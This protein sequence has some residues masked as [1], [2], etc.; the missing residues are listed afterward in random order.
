MKV[1]EGSVKE[2]ARR[3]CAEEILKS[4]PVKLGRHEAKSDVLESIEEARY[5]MEVVFRPAKMK[6]KEEKE[7]E[8]KGEKEE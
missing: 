2:F 1:K 8:E 6:E 7:K 4:C 3:W 5:Y